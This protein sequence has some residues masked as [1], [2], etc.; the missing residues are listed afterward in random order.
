MAMTEPMTDEMLE[1]IRSADRKDGDRAGRINQVS[2]RR[3]LLA[4]VDR[5]RAELKRYEWRA[6]SD[7]HEDYG[8]CVVINLIEDGCY[9]EIHHVCDL[10]FNIDDWTHFAEVPKLTTERAEQLIAEMGKEVRDGE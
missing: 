8:P 3:A 9:Q 1:L 4:E 5:L 2:H 6:I 7:I 10:D